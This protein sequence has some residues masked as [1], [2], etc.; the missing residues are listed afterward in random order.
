MYNY[1]ML[2]LALF[3]TGCGGSGLSFTEP[4][5]LEQ[6]LTQKWADFA[7]SWEAEDATACAALFHTNGQNLPP[8]NH[9]RTG[10]RDIADFYQL[11][12]H[13]NQSSEYAHTIESLEVCGDLA[14]EK[15]HFTVH[16][17]R[18]NGTDWNYQARTLAHWRRD[19]E[20]EWLL[21]TFIF[22]LPP[23]GQ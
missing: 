8:G 15:G 2:G 17:V 5:A 16:W 21:Q 1:W 3:L 12:F 14:I 22:N 19:D 4:A 20:G 18:N 6:V 11:L 10:R 23:V 9:T 7:D 13:A